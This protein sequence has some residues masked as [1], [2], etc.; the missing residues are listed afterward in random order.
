MKTKCRKYTPEDISRFVDNELVENQYKTMARHIEQCPH[1]S[2]LSK[3]YK[4][5]ST[6]FNNHVQGKQDLKVNKAFLEQKFDRTIH[7]HKKNSWKNI[8]GFSKKYIFIKIAGVA[9]ISLISLFTFQKK[10]FT[11]TGPSA[12]IKYVD[13]NYSSVMII[14]TQKEQH[15]IIWFNE[16]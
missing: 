1:C 12:I 2:Q 10:M 14:E 13:T 15:T 8:F 11:P 9:M 6:A 3:Q 5:L 7:N 16:T 4:A